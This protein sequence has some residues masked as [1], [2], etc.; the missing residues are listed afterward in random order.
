[1]HEQR[2]HEINRIFEA[3]V[4][5]PEAQHGELL[6]RECGEDDALAGA[7]L[8]L[9]ESDRRA[10]AFL[11]ESPPMPRSE[12]GGRAT[13]GP[14]SRLGAYRLTGA[15][16]QGGMGSVYLAQRDDGQFT[17]QVAIKVVRGELESPTLLQR[18]WVER[19]ILA[20]LEHPNIARLY[21]GGTTDDG[22]PYLVM[23][24]VE[25][26]P[27][28]AY[29]QRQ[30][31]ET[32][33][34]LELF[35]TVCQVV[36][37]A[38]GHRLVHRDLK[39]ANILVTDNGTV[40]LLD[41]GIAK[42]LHGARWQDQART[43]GDGVRPMTL[44]Y[45]SPEQVRGE[46]ITPAS[47]IYSLGVLLYRLLTGSSPYGEMSSTAELEKAICESDPLLA[48]RNVAEDLDTAEQRAR[49]LQGDLDLIL[50]IA[51]RKQPERRY[52]SAADL[53]D[54]LRRHLRDE[55]VQARP[56]SVLYRLLNGWR[57]TRHRFLWAAVTV[58]ILW[59]FTGL[60][61]LLTPPG[62][63][64]VVSQQTGRLALTLPE[65]ENRT[66]DPELDW[67]ATAVPERL[68]A[69]LSAGGGLRIVSP[70][71]SVLLQ[72]DLELTGS[73]ALEPAKDGAPRVRFDF[74]LRQVQGDASLGQ[75]SVDG[76]LDQPL[77][78]TE[79]SGREIRR[80]L[81]LA[82]PTPQEVRLALS[83]LPQD[84]AAARLY[85]RGLVHL[86]RLD[87]PMAR[88][89][90]EQAFERAPESPAVATA[91]SRLWH[92]LGYAQR[93]QRAAERALEGVEG[94]PRELQLVT[95][96]RLF[97]TQ[98][99]WEK[100]EEHY[101]SLRTFFPDNPE[102]GLRQAV[103]ATEAGRHERALEVLATLR[104]EVAN[105]ELEALVDFEE[106][107]TEAARGHFSAA[108]SRAREAIQGSRDIGS[109]RLE[110]RARLLEI[111]ALDALGNHD[112]ATKASFEAGQWARR[113][114]DPRSL[115]G[116]VL[117]RTTALTSNLPTELPV[118]FEEALAI[119]RALGDRQGEAEILLLQIHRKLQSSE[120]QGDAEADIQLALSIA[121]ETHNLSIE[122]GVWNQAGTLQFERGE[123]ES[124]GE[125]F[126]RAVRCARSSGD[127]GRLIRGLQNLAVS[128]HVVQ[129]L[130]QARLLY[131]EAVVLGR[132]FGSRHDFGYMLVNYAW[133]MLDLGHLEEAESIFTEALDIGRSTQT[134]SLQ[135]SSY[136]GRAGV[137]RLLERGTSS[138][139]D[140][141][142]S[143]AAFNALGDLAEADNV[144]TDLCAWQVYEGQ[145]DEAE[146]ALLEMESRHP[147]SAETQVAL[148]VHQ[149]LAAVWAAQERYGRA[150][151]K[152]DE[153]LR[154]DLE[155]F[156]DNHSQI[157]R[158]AACVQA[159]TGDLPGAEARL[160]RLTSEAREA[161]LK[162]KELS[163]R[164]D[165]GAILRRAGREDQGRAELRA[166]ADQADRLG[167][168][169]I[170]L[171]SDR[172][173]E[174]ATLGPVW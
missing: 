50:A 117:A 151:A 139:E 36:Q 72:G 163:I 21:E 124:A 87:L 40:K 153:L 70:F 76:P 9:L 17:R 79:R 29:C 4:E 109:D 165:L 81:G 23:E 60:S 103:A 150:Q 92:E 131:Q 12:D 159:A 64:P 45:A 3:L 112:D 68:G 98:Y 75:L 132:D 166:V 84:A 104:G 172:A 16:S 140:L 154:L 148:N 138:L 86:R 147:L 69:N 77:E 170:T 71:E 121:Q 46:A 53:A 149:G 119:Y 145:A 130:D 8:A 101:A 67:L 111:Q 80:V 123:V 2:W 5:L 63:P 94:L 133:L 85:T 52:R 91:L 35:A 1:M 134:L 88:Q 173:L 14:G 118:T 96:A 55:P 156:P 34:L 49:H 33:Q 174:T 20:D 59:G 113:N 54:D 27:I 97:E 126:R 43:T 142:A 168:P 65:L 58:G 152:L 18:F 161:G 144:R 128:L 141:K 129:K 115:A 74:E 7:V 83:G 25:G 108:L 30:A 13:F 95:E 99:Q 116:I 100:A 137:R 164:L 51:L 120:L 48:S 56:D 19:Q 82:S 47:D 155:A 105:P 37:F 102:H 169:L 24:Y 146:A 66:G 42:P 136:R 26:L 157:L 171:R 41:F 44:A 39:A 107:R 135:A 127:L 110:I 73:Y 106:A 28:D 57:R 31:L 6:K 167:F 62:P 162:R 22:R 11:L 114:D 15:L 122:A 10:E 143:A 78:S 61:H 160:R 158:S 89:L 93:A 90:L 125:A 38:H 32:R